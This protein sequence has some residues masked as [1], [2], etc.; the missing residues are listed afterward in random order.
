MKRKSN[1]WTFVFSLLPGAGQMY[2]GF[3]KQGISIMLAF[4]LTIFLADFLRISFVLALLPVIW[5]YGFF[6]SIN[7][8][9]LTEEELKGIE[10]KS[11]FSG[12]LSLNFFSSTGRYIWVGVILIVTGALLLLDR[13]VLSELGRM[14]LINSHMAGEYIR[15]FVIAVAIIAIGIRLISG[16][17]EKD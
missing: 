7:K 17:K 6:D 11:I 12:I 15:T 5:C 10:D 8:I 14:N 3:M 1:F 4:F 13:I 16:K 2:L 9:G